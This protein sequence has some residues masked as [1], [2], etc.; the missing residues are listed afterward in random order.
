MFYRVLRIRLFGG[1]AAR[2]IQ[3]GVALYTFET[4]ILELCRCADLQVRPGSPEA[5]TMPAGSFAYSPCGFVFGFTGVTSPM[6]GLRGSVT[7]LGSTRV[8]GLAQ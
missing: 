5:L 3:G 8:V 4:G 7:M 2:S 6:A 1:I